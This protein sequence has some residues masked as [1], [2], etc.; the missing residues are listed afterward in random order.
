MCRNR[1]VIG[2]RKTDVLDSH[3]VYAAQAPLEP[4]RDIPVEILVSQQTETLYWN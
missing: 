3:D 1:R 2:S 4:A